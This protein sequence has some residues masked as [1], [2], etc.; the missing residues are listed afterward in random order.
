MALRLGNIV[1]AFSLWFILFLLG[2]GEMP[3]ST[4][5]RVLRDIP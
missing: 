1:V 5:A 2:L 4:E 3:V